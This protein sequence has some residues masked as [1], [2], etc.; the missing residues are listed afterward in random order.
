MVA[1]AEANKN[2]IEKAKEINTLME[3]RTGSQ[4]V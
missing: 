1:K 3:I 4:E 2:I